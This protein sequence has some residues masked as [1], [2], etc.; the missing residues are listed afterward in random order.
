MSR[1]YSKRKREPSQKALLIAEAATVSTASASPK[2]KKQQQQQQQQQQQARP[3]AAAAAAASASS[4]KKKKKKQRI[5]AATAAAAANDQD[6]DDEE[7]EEEEKG[8]KID[9]QAYY[10]V[11]SG[12]KVAHLEAV[13]SELVAQGK[14]RFVWLAGDSSMD[15]KRWLF[16]PQGWIDARTDEHTRVVPRGYKIPARA[17]VPAVNGMEHILEPAK[18]VE[19]VCHWL[20]A[21]LSQT[22]GFEDMAVMMTSVEA[23]L[24]RDRENKLLAQDMFIRDHIGAEDVLIVSVGGNDVAL[25]PTDEIYSLMTELTAEAMAAEALGKLPNV[26]N[27]KLAPFISLLRDQLQAYIV[28]LVRKTRPRLII[29]CAIYFP[30]EIA[31]SSWAEMFFQAY[32]VSPAFFQ[33]LIR[34]LFAH[35]ISQVRVPGVD[36]VVHVPLY[37]VLDPKDA[38]HYVKRV[39]PSSIGGHLMAQRFLEE[40]TEAQR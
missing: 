39:E 32:D 31:G 1:E 7:Q 24:L 12:H 2:K 21:E 20:N 9:A 5:S 17:M 23:S 29:V 6:D 8:D 26:S 10:Q 14:T 15:N 35:A 25:N 19:D 27:A 36:R 18:S 4:K 11:W 30:C 13:H 33:S 37:N 38:T 40:I 3:A 28:K 16:R 34:S 22:E